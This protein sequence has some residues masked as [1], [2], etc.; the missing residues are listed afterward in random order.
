MKLSESMTEIR[1][2]RDE[3]SQR[4]LGMTKEERLKESE[5]ALAWL[6]EELNRPLK[7]VK[8]KNHTIA[9]TLTVNG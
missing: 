9:L 3:N 8:N 1:K 6:S 5:Q 7:I 4:R 2:I